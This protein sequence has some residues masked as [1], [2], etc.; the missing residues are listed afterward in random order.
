MTHRC[1]VLPELRI[2]FKW[3]A[4]VYCTSEIIELW[5]LVYDRK[6]FVVV[7]SLLVISLLAISHPLYL[8]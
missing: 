8:S 6:W 4:R 5:E 7:V 1:T 2:K 3:I